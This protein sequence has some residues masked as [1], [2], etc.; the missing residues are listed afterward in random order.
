MKQYHSPRGG[1]LV[2]GL[3]A[4]LCSFQSASAAEAIPTGKLNVDRSLVRVGSRSQLDWQIH[5]PTVTDVVEIT[6]PNIIKLKQDLKMRVRV[7][8]VSFQQAKSNN[9]HGNNEDGVDSSNPG[10]GGPN[11]AIDL[12]G[13]S[14]DEIKSGNYTELPIEV[15]WNINNSSWARIFYGT[16]TTVNATDIVLDTTVKKGDRLNF[17]GRGYRDKA[18]LPFYHTASVSPNVVLLKNGDRLPSTTPAFQLGQIESF[19]APYLAADK[20]TVAIGNRDLI[21]LLELGEAVPGYSGFNLQD[22]AVLVTFE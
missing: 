9:G 20:Q 12:S 3:L 8:G 2:I 13:G 18:W 10:T 4:C 17:G 11:G 7:L 15:I 22:V 6:T 1:R 16:Q 14:D 5:H 21:L 19:L